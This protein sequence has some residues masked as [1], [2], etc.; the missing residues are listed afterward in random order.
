M[1]KRQC[2]LVCGCAWEA[3][4]CTSNTRIAGDRYKYDISN[5]P[6]RG[7]VT[8][9]AA[10]FFTM[11]SPTKPVTYSELAYVMN[12]PDMQ[13]DF[14]DACQN[15]ALSLLNHMDAFENVA[16]PLHSVD[17]LVLAPSFKQKWTP[18]AKVSNS[19]YLQCTNP[20]Q[21]ISLE[22]QGPVMA[23]SLE[24]GIFVCPP[25]K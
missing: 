18:L 2:I 8:S 6:F 11:S 16:K 12:A 1:E 19:F 23:F 3:F 22:L 5:W 24:C 7:C 4:S 17:I 14:S 13:A 21:A 25:Q 10:G 9:P 20:P 15:L